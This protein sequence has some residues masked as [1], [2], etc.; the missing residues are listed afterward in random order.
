MDSLEEDLAPFFFKVLRHIF[1]GSWK[2][3][4]FQN[5]LPQQQNKFFLNIRFTSVCAKNFAFEVELKGTN[6]FNSIQLQYFHTY[7]KGQAVSL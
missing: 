5:W 7:Q 6:K 1:A 3:S 2:I 4:I